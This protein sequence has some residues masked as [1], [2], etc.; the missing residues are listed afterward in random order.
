M[1]RLTLGITLISLLLLTGCGKE[2][3]MAAPS[4]PLK[5]GYLVVPMKQNI[6]YQCGQKEA[7]LADDGMF[8]C[9]T[10]PVT[11][12]LNAKA[13]G[14]INSLHSDGYVFPQDIIHQPKSPHQGIHV[15]S[16]Y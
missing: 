12:Y 9:H 15:A 3:Q 2:H 10:F 4:S 6:H 11:F 13:I 14:S 8:E 16:G 5:I 7:A 1:K